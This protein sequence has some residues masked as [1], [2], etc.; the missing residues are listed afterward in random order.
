MNAPKLTALITALLCASPSAAPA[1]QPLAPAPPAGMALI[2]AGRYTP[3][4][5][6]ANDPKTMPVASFYF[7]ALPVTNGDFLEFVRA[8]PKWRRSAVKALLAD[9]DYLKSWAADLD[10]GA[11]VSSNAPATHVSWFAAKAYAAWKQKRLPTTAEWEYAAAASATRADGG[12]DPKFAAEVRAWYATPAP[13]VLPSVGR[14]HANYFGLYDL[15]GLTW[16]W[17]ADFNT[18]MVTGDARGDTG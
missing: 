16:E 6:A 15:H 7:D 1:S 14:G 9:N 8:N 12:S 2:P 17:V 18:S 13:T 10:L 3:L 5:T 4:F 11:Q